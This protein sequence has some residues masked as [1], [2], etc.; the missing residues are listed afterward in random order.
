MSIRLRRSRSSSGKETSEDEQVFLDI[1][2]EF[3]DIVEPFLNQDLDIDV[4]VNG[5][6]T[7]IVLTPCDKVMKKQWC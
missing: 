1:P 6:K 2:A 3:R 5:V 4:R 7:V